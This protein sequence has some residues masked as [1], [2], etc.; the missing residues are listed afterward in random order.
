MAMLVCFRRGTIRVVW[1][2][3][4]NLGLIKSRK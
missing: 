4:S 3:S 1:N 2:P